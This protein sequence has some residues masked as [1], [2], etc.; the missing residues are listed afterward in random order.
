MTRLP[1]A[2]TNGVT[3]HPPSTVTPSL[4][5][6]N[7]ESVSLYLSLYPGAGRVFD[8]PIRAMGFSRLREVGFAS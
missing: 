8:R 6:P 4:R 3:G 1:A 7:L 5:L 2:E